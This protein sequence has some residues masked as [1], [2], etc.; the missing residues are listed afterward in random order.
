MDTHIK[1]PDVVT[2]TALL[3]AC[4]VYVSELNLLSNLSWM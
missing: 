2:L 4:R 3:G 1:D